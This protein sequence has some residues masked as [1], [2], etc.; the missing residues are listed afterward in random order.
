MAED[1]RDKKGQSPVPQKVKPLSQSIEDES[2][3][4]ESVKIQER[5][6]MSF[7]DVLRVLI[8]GD[9]KARR[10]GWDDMESY[11]TMH[12][13]YLHYFKAEDKKMHT[14]IVGVGD[15]VNDDWIII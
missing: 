13:G 9:Y 4:K 14:L 3:K 11:I 10:I 8:A 6:P 5:T 7:G 15:I 1:K 12:A 2:E